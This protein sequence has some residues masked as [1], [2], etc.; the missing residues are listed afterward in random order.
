MILPAYISRATNMAW[1]DITF[2]GLAPDFLTITPNAD[3]SETSVGAD[4][5]RA[6]SLNPD[7]TCLVSVT[8]Q[9]TSPT[10]RKLAWILNQMR[11]DRG[12]YVMDFSLND[13]SG[14][15]FTLLKDAYFQAG[16]EQGYSSVS[17]ERTW[18]WNA[19]LNY[20]QLASG[21]EFDTPVMDNI[22]A[23]VN[24]ALSLIGS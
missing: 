19:E 8:L 16:P 21:I 22:T 3:I 4:G 13:P 12:L 17:G 6:P 15:V 9:Q 18:V 23:E 24:S 5:S 7:F 1:G 20:D 14:S 2:D 11:V 10:N